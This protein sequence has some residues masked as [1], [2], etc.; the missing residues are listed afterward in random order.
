MKPNQL[1]PNR[2]IVIS[3]A[4]N[5]SRFKMSRAEQ[6]LF[7]YC[8]GNINNIEKNLYETIEFNMVEFGKYLELNPTRL[9]SDFKKL[10]FDLVSRVVEI[11]IGL[12]KC[13]QMNIISRVEYDD[14]KV[15]ID[16]NPKIAPFLL[17]LKNNFTKYSLKEVL[18]FRS[19]YSIRIFQ[20]LSQYVGLKTVTFEMQKL[21]FMLDIGVEE[22]KL[23]A[24]FKRKVLE[25]ALNE[26]NKTSALSFAYEEIKT[27]RKVTSIKFI[28]KKFDTPKIEY[29][30][31]DVTQ[32]STYKEL[33]PEKAEKI[34]EKVKVIIQE[35]DQVEPTPQEKDFTLVD[36]KLN[37]VAQSSHPIYFKL[38]NLGYSTINAVKLITENTPEY[39]EYIYNQSK[40]EDRTN[41]TNKAGYFGTLISQYRENYQL[42][43][44]TRKKE[45]Q[46]AID[47]ENNRVEFDRLKKEEEEKFIA[48]QPSLSRE[49]LEE[50]PELFCKYLFGYMQTF[51][52]SI[53]SSFVCDPCFFENYRSGNND[54]NIQN[55]INIRNRFLECRT[56]RDFSNLI[57]YEYEW[58]FKAV[59]DAKEILD[60]EDARYYRK[61][62]N[63][64]KVE[65]PF[66]V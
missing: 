60:P 56:L 43:I 8:I 33:T 38:I 37:Q 14:G 52:V 39:L 28:I 12:A 15:K 17:E 23:Y 35:V 2:Q 41:V 11:D 25:K 34:K 64:P 65:L 3:N 1:N 36:D 29:D 40:I 19:L 58:L 50:E 45:E 18:R 59:F 47:Y 66:K 51:V 48:E 55:S 16:I 21:R 49:I 32:T 22:Y 13:I 10:T 54:Q 7:L 46:R 57:K 27:G 5:E 44:E 20:I 9:Y 4:L 61:A 63:I 26:I 31:I 30:K 24:D 62:H 6:K 42:D 53:R